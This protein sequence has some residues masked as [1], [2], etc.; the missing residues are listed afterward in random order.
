MV[1]AFVLLSVAPYPTVNFAEVVLS[2]INNKISAG[3]GN[4]LFDIEAILK[5]RIV[6]GI[7]AEIIVFVIFSKLNNC[8]LPFSGLSLFVVLL[9][10]YCCSFSSGT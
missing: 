2:F 3:D 8:S 5:K 1:L 7:V 6:R 9:D 4:K 10:K